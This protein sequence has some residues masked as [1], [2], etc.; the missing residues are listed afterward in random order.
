MCLLLP[1]CTLADDLLLFF[2]VHSYCSLTTRFPQKHEHSLGSLEVV[3]WYLHSPTK[4]NLADFCVDQTQTLGKTWLLNFI[5][6]LLIWLVRSEWDQFFIYGYSIILSTSIKYD[7][8]FTWLSWMIYGLMRDKPS[9]ALL[10]LLEWF[11]RIPFLNRIFHQPCII[12]MLLFVCA[13]PFLEVF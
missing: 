4:E 3:H 7:M 12:S 5:K 10:N 8:Y 11:F 1:Y 6:T 2:V 13:K 9:F